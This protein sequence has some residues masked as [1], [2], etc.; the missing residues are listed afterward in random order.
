MWDIVSYCDE[1]ILRWACCVI[2]SSLSWIHFYI[3][4]I[5]FRMILICTNSYRSIIG[6][7]MTFRCRITIQKRFRMQGGCT[8]TAVSVAR[9]MSSMNNVR[10]TSFVDC[11]F[12]SFLTSIASGGR[13]TPE[14]R[15]EH[16]KVWRSC[17]CLF[18][19]VVA[20]DVGYWKSASAAG[21]WSLFLC[22]SC[23]CHA[24]SAH[25][26]STLRTNSAFFS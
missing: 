7:S 6:E 24:S 2:A 4:A 22:G 16:P 17:H 3:S 18:G 8:N 13:L 23:I 20:C 15:S 14:F 19:K 12:L 10:A 5:S 1:F 25:L 26:P 11:F 21:K 9:W